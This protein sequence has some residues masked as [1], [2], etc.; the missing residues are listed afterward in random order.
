M[1]RGDERKACGKEHQ[2]EPGETRFAEPLDH[3][4]QNSGANENTHPAKVHHEE[5]Y[6]G[7]GYGKPI[8][9]VQRKRRSGAIKGTDRAAVDAVQALRKLPALGDDA[10]NGAG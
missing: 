9:K 5:A 6:V 2:T 7:L 3:A 10:P 8:G 4:S 1:Y